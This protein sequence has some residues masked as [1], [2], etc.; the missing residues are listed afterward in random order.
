MQLD[1]DVIIVGGGPAGLSAGIVF[2]SHSLRTLI[3]EKRTLPTDKACGEGVMP[4]GLL[5]LEKLQVIQKLRPGEYH[6]FKGVRY[7]I[8]GLPPASGD[9]REGPGWGIRRTVLSD[10]F[11]R[12]ANELDCLE[13]RS[14]LREKVRKFERVQGG[15]SVQVGDHE[16]NTRLLV[17]ADGLDSRVRR[18]A[19]LEGLSSALQ[20]WGARQH[21]QVKPWSEYVE[22]YWNNG[23]EAYLTPCGE[24]MVG[25]A[26][27]WD[28][29][30][31]LNVR[32]GKE[33][34]PSLM[35]RF[36]ALNEKLCRAMP[37][38]DVQA[39]GP[40]SRI[41][42]RPAADGIILAGDAAGYL[43]AITGEGISLAVKQALAIQNTVVPVLKKRPTG[44]IKLEELNEYV[45][46]YKEIVAPYTQMTNLAV[47]LSRHPGYA[48][49]T[50][51]LL[52]KH[53]RI[54]QH[55]L[56]VNMGQVTLWAGFKKVL[57]LLIKDQTLIEPRWD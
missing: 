9:F 1:Y 16:Y 11:L 34:F 20:R 14:G 32:G 55:L 40:L 10:A 49:L 24:D 48:Q 46:A 47:Y 29:D 27:L 38:G 35:T 5:A 41:V 30:K 44:M 36:P 4:T 50:V 28:R 39:V 54:F 45:K 17:G 13:I 22:V 53:P 8:E 18:W 43:D 37:C 33:L 51:R 3:L 25:V 19:G 6:S 52:S 7:I 2:A 26:I 21:Y 56:S 42:T 15:I 31:P 57:D 12:R 23:V